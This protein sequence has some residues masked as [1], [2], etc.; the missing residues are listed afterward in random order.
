METIR[1]AAELYI[2]YKI[3]FFKCV[4]FLTLISAEP[5]GEIKIFTILLKDELGLIIG[6]RSSFTIKFYL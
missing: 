1:R 6:V 3:T 4:I 2:C 5:N